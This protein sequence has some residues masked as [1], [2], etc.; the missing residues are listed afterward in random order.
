MSFIADFHI[1]S[2][3]SRATSPEMDL[4]HLVQAARAKG[5]SLIGTGDFTH[6]V[7]FQEL[8]KKLQP[9]AEGIYAYRGLRFILTVEVCNIFPS[10]NSI[11]RIHN[12]VFLPNLE[13]VERL[14]LKLALYGNLAS[15]GRPMLQLSADDLVGLV[16]DAAEFGF[17]VPAHI[18]TP[19]FSLFGSKSG[20]DRIEDCFP[21]RR[22]E[23]FALETG[24]SSDPAMNWRL[25]CLDGY[26]LISNSDA[27]SPAKIG[28][29]VN[30]F[31]EALDYC[32]LFNVLK[33]KDRKKFLGT[34]EYFPEE[35][36]YHYDGHRS[37]KSSLSPEKAIARKNLCPVC[38][39]K[40]TVGVLHRVCDL[41]D[42][43]E[44][45][46]PKNSIPFQRMVPLDQ[47]IAFVLKRPVDSPVVKEKYQTLIQDLAP[48]FEILLSLPESEIERK[49]EPEIAA[50]I[51]SVRRGRVKVEPGYDG[52]FG[53]VEIMPES[54]VKQ[55][56]LFK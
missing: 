8:K 28:R 7:W 41:A 46:I 23:I 17:V 34:V 48:E 24:L 4:E 43:P 9:V 26:S 56:R 55:A 29:E 33:K 21:K 6:P 50:A 2:K 31:R 53:K 25:S 10:H 35:G 51:I 47:I 45:T 37:C 38:G 44:G 30:V 42:R 27:H 40:I 12:V 13:S 14:S 19:H 3:Y 11:K 32:E 49:A 16:K 5:I 15:D 18:W 54:S 22:A 1:H 20:F 39:R 52:E 36:K